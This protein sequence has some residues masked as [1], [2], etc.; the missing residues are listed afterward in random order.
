MRYTDQSAL[1]CEQVL[2]CFESIELV[3]SLVPP[4]DEQYNGGHH[5][6]YSEEADY[7]QNDVKLALPY[8]QTGNTRRLTSGIVSWLHRIIRF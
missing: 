5:E 4:H 6:E 7:P 2:V 3:C 1:I 8:L